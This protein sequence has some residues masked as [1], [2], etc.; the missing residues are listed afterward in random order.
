MKKKNMKE[1]QIFE[2]L[3]TRVNYLNGLGF[4]VVYIGLYGSQNYDLDD[5]NSDIDCRAIVIP[6]LEQIIKRE[7]I[8]QVIKLNNGECDVKDLITY[9]DVIKKGNFS[10]IEPMRTKYWSGSTEVREFFEDIKINL[11]AAYGAMLEK[12]KLLTKETPSQIEDIK[13]YGYAPKQL[14]HIKRLSDLIVSNVTKPAENKSYLSYNGNSREYLLKLKRNPELKL[15][16][17]ATLAETIISHTK[18]F[19][20]T[21]YKYECVDRTDEIVKYIALDIKSDIACRVLKEVFK[22]NK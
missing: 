8:S 18:G 15:E 7:S 2:E 22:R 10:F 1:E 12:Q 16:Q 17:A 11:M 5:D 13:K 3:T 4:N 21:D 20:P 19:I 6:T 14:H 9:N